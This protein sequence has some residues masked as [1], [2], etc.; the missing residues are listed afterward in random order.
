M[1]S[2]KNKTILVMYQINTILGQLSITYTMIG[3]ILFY[4]IQSVVKLISDDDT[5]CLFSANFFQEKNFLRIIGQLY[6]SM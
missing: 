1:V 3:L 2:N 5:I 4:T 6:L